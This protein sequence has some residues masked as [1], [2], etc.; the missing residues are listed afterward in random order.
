M[1]EGEEFILFE[2]GFIFKQRLFN[3]VQSKVFD[4][5]IKNFIVDW[6]YGWVIGVFVDVVGFG[7]VFIDLVLKF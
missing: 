4:Q 1:W 7:N 3:W 2:G 5:L 6:N